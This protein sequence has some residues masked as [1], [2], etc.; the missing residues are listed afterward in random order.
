MIKNFLG[1]QTL[2]D[3]IKKLAIAYRESLADPESTAAKIAAIDATGR[4]YGKAGNVTLF[5]SGTANLPTLMLSETA[6]Q[7]RQR[8]NLGGPQ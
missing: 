8:T 7:L 4:A 2:V 1:A 5:H 6:P 3:E